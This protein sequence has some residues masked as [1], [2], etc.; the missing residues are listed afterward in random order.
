MTLKECYEI[1]GADYDDVMNR[2]RKEDRVTRFLKKFLDDKSFALL[3]ESLET[4][5]M[6]EAFRAAHT[7]KGVSQ[8]LSLSNLYTPSSL[9]S[10][11]LKENRAGGED[12]RLMFEQVK[13]EYQKTVGAVSRL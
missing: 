7:L 1:L 5:N 6:E 9:L 3:E 2:L 4:G 13:T 12:V 10:D 11:R 8:N